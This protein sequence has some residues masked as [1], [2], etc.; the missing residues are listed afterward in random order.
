VNSG[1]KFNDLAAA[2]AAAS[3]DDELR[4]KGGLRWHLHPR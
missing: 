2:I 1:A 3:P 4:V